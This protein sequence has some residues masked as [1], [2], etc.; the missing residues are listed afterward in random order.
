[1]EI[2]I[3]KGR[4]SS[5]LFIDSFSEEGKEFLKSIGIKFPKPGKERREYYFESFKTFER[6]L[7]TNPKIINY[8]KDSLGISSAKFGCSHYIVEIPDNVDNWIIEDCNGWEWITVPHPKWN[9]NET[10]KHKRR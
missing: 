8:V 6:D 10:P 5:Q 2:I 9:N 1:M 7:R 4:G 3:M